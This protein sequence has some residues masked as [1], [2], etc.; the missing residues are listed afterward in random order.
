MLERT[1]TEIWLAH[2]HCLSRADLK[3]FS[4]YWEENINKLGIQQR[5][6]YKIAIMSRVKTCQN[7]GWGV[8]EP[9]SKFAFSQ[10]SDFTESCG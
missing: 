3:D 7:G 10:C 1:G 9:L 5:K 4:G 8:V 2:Y 6:M